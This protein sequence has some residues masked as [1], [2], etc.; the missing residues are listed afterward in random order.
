MMIRGA[1]TFYVGVSVMGD[2]ENVFGEGTPGGLRITV[3]PDYLASLKHLRQTLVDN[4]LAFVERYDLEPQWLSESPD[5]NP[6]PRQI[7]VSTCA[8]DG[9]RI[10]ADSEGFWYEAYLHQSDIRIGSKRI[11]F[12]SLFKIAPETKEAADARVSGRNDFLGQFDAIEVQPVREDKEGNCETCPIEDAMFFSV[13]AHRH[14]GGVECLG[15]CEDLASAVRLGTLIA[16]GMGVPF[17]NL[18]EPG[19]GPSPG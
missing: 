13:Y 12:N 7:K 17:Y 18:A 8:L 4:G 3:T 6:R 10:V 15:D 5:E 2:A 1:K 14:S 11:A 16:S 19:T 9:T